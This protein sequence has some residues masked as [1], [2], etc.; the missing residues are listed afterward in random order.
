[1]NTEDRSS[2]EQEQEATRNRRMHEYAPA[3]VLALEPL[4][5]KAYNALI[6]DTPGVPDVEGV[7]AALEAMRALFEEF[8]DD[9]NLG[10]GAER[11]AV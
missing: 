8:D 3:V 1:M 6:Y 10:R 7:R 4:C 5:R 9:V 11:E 2:L